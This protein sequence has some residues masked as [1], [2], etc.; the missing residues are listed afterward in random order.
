M[1]RSNYQIREGDQIQPT[2]EICGIGNPH[3]RIQATSSA[4][5]TRAVIRK[6]ARSGRSPRSFRPR[7]KMTSTSMIAKGTPMG[8]V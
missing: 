7:M 1:Q 2:S 4:T 3:R 5:A 8:R 6:K